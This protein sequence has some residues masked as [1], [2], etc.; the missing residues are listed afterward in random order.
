MRR[1]S[2]ELR[3]QRLFRLQNTSSKWFMSCGTLTSE[4]MIKLWTERLS[5][6]WGRLLILIHQKGDRGLDHARDDVT[7]VFRS[8]IRRIADAAWFP[9]HNTVSRHQPLLR[10]AR[11]KLSLN[12]MTMSAEDEQSQ[13]GYEDGFGGPGAPT[14]LTAL[15]V[16]SFLSALV[17]QS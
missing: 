1:R 7:S 15:E 13:S 16:Y 9:Q 2:P 8:W 5:P 11:T 4:C 6:S 14:P 12:Y 17:R 3:N 10:F